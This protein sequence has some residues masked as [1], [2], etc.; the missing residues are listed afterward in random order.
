MIRIIVF[1]ALASGLTL[2]QLNYE[3][4]P[5]T[6][7]TEYTA[8]E[9]DLSERIAEERDVSIGTSHL[10]VPSRPQ[11]LYPV[12]RIDEHLGQA[13]E[14]NNLLFDESQRQLPIQRHR[15]YDGRTSARQFHAS[16]ADPSLPI[17]AAEMALN[18]FLNSKTPE[19]S[20]A[21]LDH[22]L[23]SQQTPGDQSSRLATTAVGQDK[24]LE[25]L[26]AA[27]RQ[28]VSQMEQTQLMPQANQGQLITSQHLVPRP[29]QAIAVRQ[30][31][32]PSTVG[33]DYDYVLGQPAVQAAVQPT[34]RPYID[35]KIQAP[36]ILQS[37]PFALNLQTRN[38]AIPPG[39][40]RQRMRRI[41]GKP[42]PFAQAK[43]TPGLYKGPIAG[44]RY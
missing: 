5:L 3:G 34:I 38:D 2:G 29:D 23:R 27:Q 33:Q 43:V 31:M 12:S 26:D 28:T 7:Y 37:A 25:L 15:A 17:S 4:N 40:W 21:A 42:F 9:S 30:Q 13:T 8:E 32:L 14:T 36:G 22:Y 11:K 24:K 1:L 35:Q 6:E 41:R 18:T 20:Q 19:E 44:K 39:M 16:A 10:A